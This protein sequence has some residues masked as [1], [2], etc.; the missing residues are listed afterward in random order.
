MQ[1]DR[2]WWL[3]RND[4]S[5]RDLDA[6]DPFVEIDIDGVPQGA[7]IISGSCLVIINETERDF[8]VPKTAQGQFGSIIC[9]PTD[10]KYVVPNE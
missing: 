6:S 1:P 2:T 10:K 7:E 4:M 5:I 3:D 8:E 9:T